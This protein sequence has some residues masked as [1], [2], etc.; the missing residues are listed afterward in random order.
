[1]RDRT[2]WE[3]ARGESWYAR[4]EFKREDGWIGYFYRWEDA[5]TLIWIDIWICIVPCF[6]VHIMKAWR[7]PYRT[8][9][10]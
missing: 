1:M 10:I 7:I 2:I 3:F 6:P 5:I 4:L 9:R 8:K